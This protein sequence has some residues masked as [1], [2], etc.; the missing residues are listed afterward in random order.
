MIVMASGKT[1]NPRVRSFWVKLYKFL[2]NIGTLGI[3]F[4]AV[5]VLGGL[6]KTIYSCVYVLSFAFSGNQ[7]FAMYIT[8]SSILIFIVPLIKL[9]IKLIKRHQYIKDKKGNGSFSD[10]DDSG[11]MQS[12]MYVM[13]NTIIDVVNKIPYVGII[14]IVNLGLVI[15][16]NVMNTF[17]TTTNVKNTEIYMAVATFYAVDRMCA[18]F[19]K[20]YAAFWKKVDNKIFLTEEINKEI[21]FDFKT[22]SKITKEMFVNY[23][24][25][26]KCELSEEAKTL[27]KRKKT[28]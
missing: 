22:M 28:S 19:K 9:L 7:T 11:C 5:I 10:V 21:N 2:Y 1:T 16:S 3:L 12:L 17:N 18:Y 27:F 4:S 15:A 25:T 8:L 26:G 13:S 24:S 6:F 20:E 14:H 23:I